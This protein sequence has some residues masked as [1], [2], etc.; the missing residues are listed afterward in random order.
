[1]GVSVASQT[2]GDHNL[3]MR[4]VRAWLSGDVVLTHSRAVRDH[5]TASPT[6]A[7]SILAELLSDLYIS[8]RVSVSISHF[9]RQ[10]SHI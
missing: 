2:M 4:M 7:N 5:R 3:E 1:M 6:P 10:P 8:R 9:R